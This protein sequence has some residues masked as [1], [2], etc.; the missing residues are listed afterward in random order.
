MWCDPMNGCEL[1][2]ECGLRGDDL[3]A[4]ER[5]TG[6]GSVIVDPVYGFVVAAK[7]KEMET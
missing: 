3:A 6:T 4:T 1:R 2:I 7:D 5:L